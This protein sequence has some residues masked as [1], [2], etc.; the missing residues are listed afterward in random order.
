M[1]IK[2]F[3]ATLIKVKRR[4]VANLILNTL[5]VH[6]GRTP[7]KP[8]LPKAMKEDHVGYNL[9]RMFMFGLVKMENRRM[10]TERTK[11][12]QTETT[13]PYPE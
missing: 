13:S 9:S 5:L 11:N 6:A 1:K 2:G 3:T 7:K 8:A 4:T 12:N 10:E